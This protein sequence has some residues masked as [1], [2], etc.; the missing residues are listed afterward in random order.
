MPARKGRSV[1]AYKMLLNCDGRAFLLKLQLREELCWKEECGWMAEA[2]HPGLIGA[3][4]P[5]LPMHKLASVILGRVPRRSCSGAHQALGWV[6]KQSKWTLKNN[7]IPWCVSRKKYF[8]ANGDFIRMKTHIM[9]AS[10]R[11]YGNQ[12]LLPSLSHHHLLY[13]LHRLHVAQASCQILGSEFPANVF[14]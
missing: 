3:A 2:Y 5:E 13:N 4:P 10:L 9:S 7:E 14:F 11:N 1:C 12:T 6:I 8:W